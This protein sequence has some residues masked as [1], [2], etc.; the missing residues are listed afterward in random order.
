VKGFPLTNP[1][2]EGA[3]L[4]VPSGQGAQRVQDKGLTAV[5][6]CESCCRAIRRSCWQV[7]GTVVNNPVRLY[8][9]EL[10]CHM[11]MSVHV[12]MAV[13]AGPG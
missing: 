9:V 8:C 5:W 2:G 10:R 6:Q 1:W 4:R 11:R 13:M 7:Q 3:G 12:P